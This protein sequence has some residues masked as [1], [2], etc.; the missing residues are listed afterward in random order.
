MM[1]TKKAIPR[2]TVLRGMGAT[3][4]LPLLDGM[5]P[6]LT[7]LAQTAAKPALRFG[8]FYVPNGI[9][10]QNWTPKAEG[11]AFELPSILQPLAPFRDRLLVLTGLNSTPPPGAGN[12][13]V[14]SRAS[15][16][17][18]TD[19]Q[20][21]DP[22][23]W[24]QRGA[25][26]MDQRAAKELGQHTEL[27]SL[28][29]GMEG[30]DFAGS[31]DSGGF[32]C[33]FSYTISWRNASTP[34]PMEHNPRAVFERLFGDSDSTDG[35]ARMARM[36]EQRSILD[37]VNQDVARLRRELS[38]S[39]GAKINAYLDAVR[40]VERRIQKAEAQ[41]DR[42]VPLVARPAGVPAS[43]AEHAGLMYDLQLLAYQADR[44]RVTTFMCGHELSG[45]T[46]P[47]I[48]VPDAHHP[49]SHHQGVQEAIGKLTKINT[50][51]MTLF[52]S[53]LEK[54]RATPDGD[55]SLLD[56]MVMIYG[57]GMSDS[58]AHSPFN[59]PILVLGGAAGQLKGGRH[60][61]YPERT[62]LANLHVTLLDKLGVRVDRMG[63]S[64]GTLPRL[65]EDG[66]PR[67]LSGI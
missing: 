47:E 51:H 42:E 14:H 20:P 3:L 27:A 56:H 4:A 34:L 67:T 10:M 39:D 61:K 24:G 26:S 50:Y 17:F 46:F 40:D 49:L 44:T 28:E 52:A 13:G 21:A 31:C 9:V 35:R 63:D 37:S 64:T 66:T 57:A 33:A 29:L 59:L 18:L 55:G 60:L 23:Q 43:F 1:I 48:G 32:S 5:V 45:R 11:S 12:G 15:T 2:R 25:I 22:G 53:F 41:S 16:R 8:A 38:P 30:A 6:A 7:A 54:L 58:N 62:P 36:R 65:F 19:I